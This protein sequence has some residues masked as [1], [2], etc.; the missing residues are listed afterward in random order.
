MNN[1]TLLSAA[2]QV[3][4][5]SSIEDD[6]LKIPKKST[7]SLI[8]YLKK[9]YVPSNQVMSTGTAYRK[10]YKAVLDA[11]QKRGV[12]MDDVKAKIKAG[13]GNSTVSFNHYKG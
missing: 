12:D 6:I 11:L 3:L 5:E 10:Y 2:A 9:S 8:A 4:T 1:N 13:S 7:D